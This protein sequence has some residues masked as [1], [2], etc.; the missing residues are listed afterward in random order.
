MESAV[1]TRA[2]RKHVFERLRIQAGIAGTNPGHLEYLVGVGLSLRSVPASWTPATRTVMSASVMLGSP[3]EVEK[4]PDV[5]RHALTDG[6][7]R[8]SV[9]KDEKGR[10]GDL[11][12]EPGFGRHDDGDAPGRQASTPPSVSHGQVPW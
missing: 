12:L 1:D 11:V 4:L 3:D 5:R 9:D 2:E 10:A 6:G 8:R 7:P